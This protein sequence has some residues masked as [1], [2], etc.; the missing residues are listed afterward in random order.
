MIMMAY[1]DLMVIEGFDVRFYL[2]RAVQFRE[3]TGA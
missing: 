3:E 1:L 2:W